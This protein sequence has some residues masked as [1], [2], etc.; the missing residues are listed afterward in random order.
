VEQLIFRT[1]QEALRNVL[2]HAEAARVRIML[3]ADE[4]RFLLRI[5]DDG[6]GF[7]TAVVA[8]ASRHGHVGLV[9]LRD[10]AADL[11]G[12]LTIQSEPGAGVAIV[13]TVPAR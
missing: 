6:R 4:E 10:R 13:L 12:E 3:T 2:D 11:G 9:L 8:D 1:A 7:D 5:E